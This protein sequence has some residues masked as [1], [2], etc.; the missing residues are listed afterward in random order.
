MRPVQDQIYPQDPRDAAILPEL[1]KEVPNVL[2]SSPQA[3][4]L[5]LQAAFQECT[6][7]TRLDEEC[8]ASASDFDERK[9]CLREFTWTN[10]G[11]ACYNA[12]LQAQK[13]GIG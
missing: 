5:F 9:K 8:H 2:E 6:D 11:S 4:R 13:L 10:E 3:S 12:H 1:R 7:S